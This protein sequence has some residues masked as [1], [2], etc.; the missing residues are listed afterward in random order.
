MRRIVLLAGALALAGCART[1]P[2]TG[3]GEAGIATT[4]RAS[5]TLAASTA[6]PPVDG[7]AD[8]DAIAPD[9]SAADAGALP[10]THDEPAAS[11]A[12]F[13]ARARALWDAVANDDPDRA[14]PFFFPV[15]A[16]EQVKAIAD[17]ASDW[18]RRLVAAYARDI[19]ALHAKLGSSAPRARFGALEVP[20]EGGRWVKPGE[21]YNKLGYYRVFGSKLRYEIEGRP[22]AF[23]VTSLISWRGE[24]YVVHLNSIR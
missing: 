6:P 8:P 2:R 11:G 15:A 4:T 20:K 7:G 12:A 1:G 21:E 23:D 5:A 14:M 24:W 3:E 16:Y 19:H 13:D 17:P 10:Q 18:R 9:A 22:A